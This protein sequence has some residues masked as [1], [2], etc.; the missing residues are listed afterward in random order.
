MKIQK[1]NMPTKALE[2][3]A[4]QSGKTV[5]QA[6]ACWDKAKLAAD[7]KF[8]KKEGEYWSYVNGATKKCL[9]I[10]PKPNKIKDW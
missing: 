5:K 4:K 9:G 7:K 1:V 2:K 3:L 8:K 10:K 6:E